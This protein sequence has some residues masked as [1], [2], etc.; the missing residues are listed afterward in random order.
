MKL[1]VLTLFLLLDVLVSGQEKSDSAN[2]P[3]YNQDQL[4]N[5][6]HLIFKVIDFI[7]TTTNRTDYIKLIDLTIDSVNTKESLE[8]NNDSLCRAKEI[9]IY[10]NKLKILATNEN[11]KV[12]EL[13]R[14]KKVEPGTDLFFVKKIES[15]G[16]RKIGG[17][18]LEYTIL[19]LKSLKLDQGARDYV[20]FLIARIDL[21]LSFECFFGY[22]NYWN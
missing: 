18:R 11:F 12:A 13:M 8:H 16:I 3:I 17:D 14:E 9:I 7:P 20:E 19:R 1:F 15:G 21:C 2:I 6:D 4:K 10:L 22:V 5:I